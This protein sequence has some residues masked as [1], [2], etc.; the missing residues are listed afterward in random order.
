MNLLP[1]PRSLTRKA[2]FYV[3]PTQAVLHLDASLPRA[4]VMLPLAERLKAAAAN[5]GANLELVTGPA[6][7][8]RLAIRAFQSTAVPNH[9][10]GYT[11]EI[12]S[13][14]VRIHYRAE[15]GLRAS[16]ATLRQLLAEYGRRLPRLIIR[17]YPDFRHRGVMLDI[18][19]GRV[20]RVE[21]LM[22]LVEHLALFKINQFQLYTEHTFAYRDYEPVWK[23]WGAITADEILRLDARCRELGIEL[24]PNQNSFG[25]LRYWLEYPPAP[26]T[27]RSFRALRRRRRRFPAL[28][29]HACSRK[30]GHPALP[31]RPLRRTAAPF[32][33]HAVQRR[34][35][36]NLGSWAGPETAGFA[37]QR[38][39]A[40]FTLTSSR[41][42]T[43]K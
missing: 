17:D 30:Q 37:S 21:T 36:R 28:P 18:S 4:E 32:L 14:G 16:I 38:E 7:H 9:D 26:Q 10:E 33:Q 31:A 35:R 6:N 12:G 5:A 42:F 29:N 1:H 20:P 34:L 2:G 22:E 11:L 8:P 43:A 19:R 40:G 39:K 15:P 25:H 23:D 41:P 3:L 24:V 13:T 27:G